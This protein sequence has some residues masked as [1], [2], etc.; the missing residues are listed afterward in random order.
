MSNPSTQVLNEMKKVINGKDDVIQK[1][2]MT[3]LAGGHV[4]LEDLPGVGK[5]TLAK[6]FSRVV[7]L[8]SNRIQFTPDVVASDVIGF[9]MFDKEKNEFVFK[10]GAVM[11]NL[12]L[13]DEINRTSS[14]TQAALLEAMQEK[15]V[16]VDGATYPLPAPFHVIATQNPYGTIGTQ[17]LPSAQIDRFMTKLS[18]GYPDFEDQVDMLKNRQQADPLSSLTQV[19]TK[20]ELLALQ[21]Q[22][23][24]LFIHEE[25]LRYVTA[26]TEKTRNHPSIHQGIS[27][28]GALA[29][30]QMAKAHAFLQQRD[31]VIPEDVHA[32]WLPTSRHRIVM[33][34]VPGTEHEQD[35]LLEKLLQSVATPDQAMLATF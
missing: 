12:L 22:V 33:S 7:G 3:F 20:N 25:I 5:T 6:A 18:V 30:C 31:Y 15:Q 4:L 29:L 24:N 9:T 19:L 28:R 32:V 8:D 14:R 27:P 35:T 10:E 2:W 13:G 23:Q 26:L 11:C 34:S 16:T 1:V 21:H 17:P